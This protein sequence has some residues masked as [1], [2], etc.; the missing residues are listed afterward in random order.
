[1]SGNEIRQNVTL[2]II[3]LESFEDSEL[4]ALELEQLDVRDSEDMMTMGR[5]YLGY[6]YVTKT[7]IYR[8]PIY[9]YNGFTEEQNQA[10]I[11]L[12]K[13]DEETF[14][15][16]SH[17]VCNVEGVEDSLDEQGYHSGV[18]KEGSKRIFYYYNDDMSGTKD[19]EEIVWEREKGII[20]YKRGA[21]SMKMHIE[22][23][24]DLEEN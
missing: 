14:F 13:Q 10:I 16:M 5:R 7:N 4:Y 17:I 12:I 1:M 8:I 18:K 24:V 11:D 21:G 3:K 9:D 22:F 20:Y 23:G 2:N 15:E 6:F 19:Y